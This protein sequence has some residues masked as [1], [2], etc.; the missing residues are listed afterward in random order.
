MTQLCQFWLQRSFKQ[1][2]LSLGDCQIPPCS[3][4]SARANPRWLSSRGLEGLLLSGWAKWHFLFQRREAYCGE[5]CSSFGTC[6]GKR[7]IQSKSRNATWLSLEMQTRL[8]NPRDVLLGT[9]STSRWAEPEDAGGEKGEG[10][11]WM[12]PRM[13]R[14]AGIHAE[15][16]HMKK[17]FQNLWRSLIAKFRLKWKKVGKTTRP[18]IFDLN[19]I[20][21]IIQW[22]W[23]IDLRD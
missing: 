22:K 13:R 2:L 9:V 23:E 10:L 1:T 16:M 17:G 21:M 12:G 18:F 8:K 4:F 19:Q 7:N 11:V 15:W 20:P 5:V 6:Q 3:P 14:G